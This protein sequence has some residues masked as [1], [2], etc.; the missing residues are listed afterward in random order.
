LQNIGLGSW[1]ARRARMTPDAVALRYGTRLVSY[2]DLADQV[3][4]LAQRLRADGVC[5]GD[6]VAYLGPN[7]PAFLTAFFAAGLLGA[8][9]VPLNTRLAPP[10][11]DRLLADCTPRLLI[12]TGSV[13]PLQY[14]GRVVAADELLDPGSGAPSAPDVPVALDDPSLILY[15]SG[16]TGRP[17]GVVLTHDS[18]TWN[19]YNALIESDFSAADNT[20]VVAPLFHAAALGIVC[21][22][23]LLKG[24][25]VCLLSAFDAGSTLAAIEHERITVMFGVPAMFDAMAAHPSWPSADLASLRQVICGGAPVRAST[26][27]RYLARGVPFGQGYGSTETGPGVSMLD[28][29][30]LNSKAGSVGVPS[31]FT[32]VRIVDS[33][34]IDLPAGTPGELLIR[35][36]SVTRG[37]WQQPAA[38]ESALADG[39]FRTGDVGSADD[40]GY[41]YIVD[42]LGRRFISGGENVHPAEVE[43]VLGKLPGVAACVVVGIPDEQWGEVGYALVVPS[44][45]TE[46]DPES[47]KRLLRERLAAYKVPRQVRLV[48][49]LPMNA[50]GKVSIDAVRT[51]I[52]AG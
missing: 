23:T 17:K 29:D 28:R 43:Q 15:T 42:R 7:D 8:V 4:W 45:G 34:G 44:A 2:A 16:T 12:Y 51:A 30:H 37:Y 48:E 14:D 18:L 39:W 26:I 13:P 22:P 1:P 32:D 9:F 3:D 49:K 52:H 27:R 24:G 10:E 36:P 46:L 40:D 6:R 19:C 25:T 35:G 21:L 41:L 50:A 20:L 5:R 11:L 47:I 38:S 31:F 33:A